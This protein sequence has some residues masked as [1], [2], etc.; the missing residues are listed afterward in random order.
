MRRMFP[1]EKAPALCLGVIDNMLMFMYI[2]Y[3]HIFIAKIKN[4]IVRILPWCHARSL[5]WIKLQV[6]D[7]EVV[8]DQVVLNPVDG[9][10]THKV[11]A[12]TEQCIDR[13]I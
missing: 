4:L 6:V 8:F 1:K 7:M 10:L 9:A 5:F 13:G 12:E 3:K 11:I 2:S